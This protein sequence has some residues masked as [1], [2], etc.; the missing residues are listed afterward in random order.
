MK[1]PIWRAAIAICVVLASFVIGRAIG[2]V[3]HDS[4]F[5]A[6]PVPSLA[7]VV[8]SVKQLPSYPRSRVVFRLASGATSS[9]NGT[10]PAFATALFETP[11]TWNHVSLWFQRM[12]SDRSW[13]E[14][15]NTLR[16]GAQVKVIRYAR[17]QRM[18]FDL[19]L[20]N[21]TLLARSGHP[22]SVPRGQ[23]VYESSLVIE[24]AGS[25]KRSPSSLADLAKI[26]GR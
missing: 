12:L 1:L 25:A 7:E 18:W 21:S 24:P 6:S 19:A 13:V 22:I 2:S 8:A 9:R 23:Q 4:P 5:L 16:S 15:S 17:D 20:D 3:S 11:D 14:T 26:L 10:S